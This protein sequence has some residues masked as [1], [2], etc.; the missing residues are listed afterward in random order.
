MY[1]SH[2]IP[3]SACLYNYKVGFGRVVNHSSISW[4]YWVEFDDWDSAKEFIDLWHSEE[5]YPAIQIQT[6]FQSY[7]YEQLKEGGRIA[8]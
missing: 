8:D 2:P 6:S 7:K 5:K 3:F 4:D 1:E